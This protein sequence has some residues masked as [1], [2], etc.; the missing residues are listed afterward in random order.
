MRCFYHGHL[1]Q[2]FVTLV[3]KLHNWNTLTSQANYPITENNAFVGEAVQNEMNLHETNPTYTTPAETFVLKSTHFEISSYKRKWQH[4]TRAL[5]NL[6]K[7][8]FEDNHAKTK[9]TCIPPRPYWLIRNLGKPWRKIVNWQ[10]N[11]V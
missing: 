7:R 3:A 2:N 5:L 1:A 10:L 11:D 8:A 6:W 9:A 4:L